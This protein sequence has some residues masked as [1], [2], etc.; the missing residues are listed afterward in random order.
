M[1]RVRQMTQFSV[2]IIVLSNCK[3]FLR[4]FDL[5]LYI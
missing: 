3:T 5:G 4:R 1:R 2:L